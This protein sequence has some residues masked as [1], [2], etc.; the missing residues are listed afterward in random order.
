[1]L[2]YPSFSPDNQVKNYYPVD[3]FKC[4]E[5]IKINTRWIEVID[6]LGQKSFLYRG[7]SNDDTQLNVNWNHNQ[8]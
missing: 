1:M 7:E 3:S 6:E 5:K 2:H 4:L 8:I